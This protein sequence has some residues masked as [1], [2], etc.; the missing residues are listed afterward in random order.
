MLVALL[1][2]PAGFAHAATPTHQ[3]ISFNNAWQTAQ[4]NS[5]FLASKRADV[6]RAQLTQESLRGLSFP[7]V[8]LLGTY[9]HLDDTVTADALDFN[10]LSDLENSPAGREFI[11]LLGGHKA[12]RTDIVDQD[13]GRVALS[14]IWPVYTGGRITAARENSSA[15]TDVAIQQEAVQQRSL[16][17]E[18][19]RAYFG[20]ALAQQNLQIHEDTERDLG[21]HLENAQKLEAQGQISKVERLSIAAV[22]SRATV[23]RK[24]SERVLEITRITLGELLHEQ[25]GYDPSDALFINKNLPAEARFLAATMD[26]SPLLKEL[27]ANDRQTAALIQ[28][29]RGR[30]HPEVFLFADYEVYKDNSIVFSYIPDWQVGVGVNFKLLDRIGRSKSI[31][32]AHKAQQS[33]SSIRE[34]T[35]RFLDLATRVA[36]REANQALDQYLGLDASLE[37]AQENLK[38]RNKAFLEGFSTSVELVDAQLFLGAVKVEQSAAAYAYIVSLARLLALSGD[39]VSFADYQA[40]G[41]H[42]TMSRRTD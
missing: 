4:S 1:L 25:P 24:N 37:L 5:D 16:F 30:F 12:F 22:Y 7:S 23:S 39:L 11:D 40:R 3:L 41:H 13:F 38:L 19:V 42:L 15:L 8:D 36:Y 20:V 27:E 26:N 2:F 32:A 34:G 35:K 9:T 28:A 14:A 17:E 21:S 6:E 29:E 31:G 18:L 10:P 33:V